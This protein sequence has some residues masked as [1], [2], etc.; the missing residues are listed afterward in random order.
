MSAS[1]NHGFEIETLLLAEFPR[2]KQVVA[3]DLTLQHE[4][5]ARFDVSSFM[6]PYGNGIPTSIKTSKYTG[7]RTLVY[8]A[9]AV[10]IVNMADESRMR[11]MVALYRQV[12]GEKVFSELREYVIEGAEWAQICGNAPPEDIEAFAL[13]LKGGDHL[14]ARERAR[15]W[16]QE[17][18]AAYPSAIRWNPKIDSKTQRRLQCSITLQDL[19]AAIKDPARIK[20]FGEAIDDRPRPG[21]LRPQSNRLWGRGLRFPLHLASAP[22][23]RHKPAPAKGLPKPTPVKGPAKA[24]SRNPQPASAP[25]V[26]PA[27]RAR[28]PGVR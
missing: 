6:D 14:H 1:Q 9:D 11:L 18:R 4:H 28:R 2:R 19:E 13:D 26:A 24:S 12:G 8:L 20:V 23:L 27:P 21:Y 17:M 22:R 25:A 7:P 10:R 5:T 15:R 3:P 16:Q